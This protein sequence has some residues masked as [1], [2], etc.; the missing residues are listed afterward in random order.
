M[1]DRYDIATGSINA[2][3]R[4]QRGTGGGIRQE[5]AGPQTQMSLKWEKFISE[6]ENK[7]NLVRFLGEHWIDNIPD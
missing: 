7:R 5:I 3:E 1:F 2:D 6:T 4:S